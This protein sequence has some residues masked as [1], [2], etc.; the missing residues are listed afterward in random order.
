[1]MSGRSAA[2]RAFSPDSFDQ[3]GAEIGAP[4][5]ETGRSRTEQTAAI[6]AILLVEDNA[7]DVGLL[8]E[9]LAEHALVCDLIVLT[10]GEQA[11]DYIER[12]EQTDTPKPTIIILDLNLPKRSGREILARLRG[13]PFW[14]ATPVIVLSSSE[15]PDDLQF[16][17]VNGASLYIRKPLD[18]EEFMAIGGVIR[19]FVERQ[20]DALS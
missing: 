10:D 12:L 13:V 20:Q 7:G 5:A 8:R 9:A 4:S 14:A 2:V 19:R 15:A 18:L 17:A 11:F 16:A 3:P 6:P 1:M